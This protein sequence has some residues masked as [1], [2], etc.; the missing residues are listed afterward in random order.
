MSNA[1]LSLKRFANLMAFV[2]TLLV[3]VALIAKFIL[4]WLFHDEGSTFINLLGNIGQLIAY[5]VLVC[6]AFFYVKTKRKPIW[7]ILYAISVT[8]IIILA[9]MNFVI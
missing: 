5:L 6:V 3:A 1:D 9:I 7:Y 4:F 8:A 2:G